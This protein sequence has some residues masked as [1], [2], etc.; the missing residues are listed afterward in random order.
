MAFGRALL[1][2]RLALGAGDVALEDERPAGDA[3]QRAVR[4]GGIVLREIQLRVPGSRKKDLVRVGDRHLAAGDFD[5]SAPVARGRRR[6]T[7]ARL[8]VSPMFS[9]ACLRS[10]RSISRIVSATAADTGVGTPTSR[11]FSTT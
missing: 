1:K 10:R 3:A 8:S 6:Q 11:P 2:E 5:D 7:P 4:D 9:G